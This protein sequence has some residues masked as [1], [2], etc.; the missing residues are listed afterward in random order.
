MATLVASASSTP[1]VR[2]R[3]PVRVVQGPGA[4]APPTVARERQRMKSPGVEVVMP[5][6][7][8]Q[9]VV[10]AIAI[11]V[12]L[13]T[14]CRADALEM[15]LL[16]AVP[17][18][19]GVDRAEVDR[20]DPWREV[21][22][23]VVRRVE[24]AEQPAEVGDLW[25]VARPKTKTSGPSPPLSTSAPRPPMIVS[26]PPP[27]LIVS[28]AHLPSIVSASDVPVRTLSFSLPMMVSPPGSP[29]R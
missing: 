1:R 20:V 19:V 18:R 14:V 2:C 13:T 16:V 4:G 22:D 23:G 3:R 29:A 28:S 7:D 11:G 25:H 10:G 17:V 21:G 9:H 5:L 24:R 6:E 27:P 15:E 12:A 8:D 26:A